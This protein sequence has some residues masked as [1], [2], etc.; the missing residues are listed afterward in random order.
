M[1]GQLAQRAEPPV[2]RAGVDADPVIAAADLKAPGAQR[3]DAELAHARLPERE[4]LRVGGAEA[5]L[6]LA[7][8]SAAGGDRGV[9]VGD[10]LGD[11]LH[12]VDPALGEVL[13]KVAPARPP[14][15]DPRAIELLRSQPQLAPPPR[16]PRPA[17]LLAAGER[18]A[19]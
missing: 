19:L 16:R 4:E 18:I 8:R 12:Q 1:L 15:P 17:L 13:A 2:H 14:D 10:Q 6:D 11:D 9:G 5:E 7:V 3:R